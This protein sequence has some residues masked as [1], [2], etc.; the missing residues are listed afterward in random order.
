MLKS[1]HTIGLLLLLSL[2]S[3][4]LWASDTI[5]VA[6]TSTTSSPSNSPQFDIIIQFSDSVDDFE[7]TDFFV[8]NGYIAELR[9]GDEYRLQWKAK[10]WAFN[11]G[12]IKICLPANITKRYPDYLVGNMASDTLRLYFDNG[13]PSAQ[14]STTAQTPTKNP[15][16]DIHLTFSEFVKNFN[17]ASISYANAELVSSEEIV[18]GLQ[19]KYNFRA[20]VDGNASVFLPANVC[21]DSAGNFNTLSNTI[22]VKFDTE[23]PS[24]ILT[25]AKDSLVNSADYTF[26]ISF[27]EP[28]VG[29]DGDDFIAGNAVFKSLK[30]VKDKEIWDITLTHLSDGNAWVSL[31]ENAVVDLLGNPNVHSDTIYWRYDG[32]PPTA[33]LITYH[34]QITRSDTVWFYV[35][36]SEPMYYFTA[37]SVITS[38]GVIS[39][40]QKL[41]DATSY[42]FK[43]TTALQDWHEVY[44]KQ[45]GAFDKANNGNVKSNAINIYTDKNPPYA[46]ITCG[47]IGPTRKDSFPAYITFSEKVWGIEISD[48]YTQKCYL[49]HLQTQDSIAFSFFI[50]PTEIGTVNLNMPSGR[51]YDQLQNTNVATNFFTIEYDTIPPKM[52][53]YSPTG[54][55]QHFEFAVRFQFSEPVTGFVDTAISVVNGTFKDFRVSA[56]QTEWQ[57]TV[58]P[59][60]V[61]DVI[62]S[63]KARVAFDRAGNGN[64]LPQSLIVNFNDDVYQPT[65][66]LSSNVPTPT[67]AKE[68]EVFLTF[69]EPIY[70]L[71]TSVIR[72]QNATLAGLRMIENDSLWSVKLY[73]N[74]DGYV[75]IWLDAQA[76]TDDAQNY[77]RASNILT[78]YTDLSSPVVK[79]STTAPDSGN[80]RQITVKYTFSEEVTGFDTTDL[81]YS[82]MTVQSLTRNS[83]LSYSAVFNI[84]NDGAAS[85]WITEGS[86]FDLVGNTNTPSN[87]IQLFFDGTRPQAYI[88]SK[89]ES[90]TIYTDTITIQV[91]FSEK[92]DGFSFNN[93]QLFNAE[94]VALNY[95]P[96]SGIYEIT[97]KALTMD[98]VMA[99]KVPAGVSYDRWNNPNLASESYFKFPS[100][101]APVSVSTHAWPNDWKVTT[102]EGLLQIHSPEAMHVSSVVHVF[103][104]KGSSVVN[105]K[106]EAG[107][108]EVFTLK[109]GV[110]LVQIFA[111]G[112]LYGKLVNVP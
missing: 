59:K 87:V 14:I 64:A 97:L 79:L 30:V 50:H 6:L 67:S 16:F 81:K 26:R 34:S 36:F 49:S 73:P 56:S 62:I 89:Y 104:A 22:A 18:A 95:I 52:T 28:V 46:N 74:A 9:I 71:F 13:K 77:S 27:S 7:A 40:V 57:V 42:K 105:R 93:L 91:Y 99:A 17:P 53:I 11:Q 61:G 102:Q 10:V 107:G 66:V 88:T 48:F 111:M 112:K 19:Y 69:S 5:T 35:K 12:W 25:A 41:E 101:Q 8:E 90:D 33:T 68:I 58:V 29:L 51:G 55:Y 84:I 83:T 24:A 100:S 2:I 80:I 70:G 32:T 45:G 21:T 20:L 23:P 38:R 106:I 86:I 63:S 108:T 37:G 60:S 31:L 94:V 75:K 98:Q 65:V 92:I 72:T 78:W 4:P 15:E 3:F 96:V 85:T 110:Y 109:K 1:L 76:V 54:N 39:D 82:N 47:E 103:D 44:V 43:L